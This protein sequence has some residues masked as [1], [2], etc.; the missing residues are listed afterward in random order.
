MRLIIFASL[1][2]LAALATVAPATAEIGCLC[3][4]KPRTGSQC[5][6]G[7][8]Y[9]GTDA[10]C[11]GTCE[12]RPP[13]AAKA[14]RKPQPSFVRRPPHRLATP[15]IEPASLGSG[16]GRAQAADGDDNAGPR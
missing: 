12:L 14:T 1:A 16:T 5:V 10:R 13:A 3:Y 4:Y 11:W 8:Q 7:P 15:S 9:C 6:P 2:A